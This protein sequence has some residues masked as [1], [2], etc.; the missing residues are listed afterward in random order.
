MAVEITAHSVLTNVG[1]LPKSSTNL[2]EQADQARRLLRGIAADLVGENSQ[3]KSGYLRIR[4]DDGRLF[5]DTQSRWKSGGKHDATQFT[6]ELFKQ[7]YG[8]RKDWPE[9]SARLGKYLSKSSDRFGT[10][11]FIKLIRAIDPDIVAERGVLAKG[12]A[13][14]LPPD[15]QLGKSR[16]KLDGAIDN[17]ADVIPTNASAADQIAALEALI[18]DQKTKEHF[19]YLMEPPDIGLQRAGA[20]AST[21][22]TV[23]GDAD[24]SLSRVLVSALA[25]GHLTMSPAAMEDLALVMQKE[26]SLDP[27]DRAGRERFQADPSIAEALDRIVKGIK[28]RP[29][30]DGRRLVFIGDL[31]HDRLSNNKPAMASVIRLL[32]IGDTDP[33]PD[34]PGVIFILGNHDLVRSEGVDWRRISSGFDFSELQW[35]AAAAWQLS[36]EDNAELI[37]SSFAKAWLDRDEGRFY[38]HNGIKPMGGGRVQTALGE[39][40]ANTPEELE[41]AINLADITDRALFTNFRPAETDMSEALLGGLGQWQGKPVHYVHGHSGNF[42]VTEGVVHINARDEGGDM[43]PIAV[44]LK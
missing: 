20:V 44:E 5:V 7:A 29:S 36:P 38:C 22:T 24:G 43:K 26:A 23:V 34:R 27:D 15:L 39:V 14:T 19:A 9:I 35:G 32:T 25:S 40:T 6:R 16:L 3:V 8:H 2:I 21:K 1:P 18:P 11:S 10:Q 37:R 4:T 13:P 30:P 28:E 31:L 12:E 41:E 17:R 42:G 33:A